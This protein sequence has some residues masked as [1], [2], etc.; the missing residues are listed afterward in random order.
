MYFQYS[1]KINRKREGNILIIAFFKFFLL[2]FSFLFSFPFLSACQGKYLA[3]PAKIL[4]Y[5]K[6]FSKTLLLNPILTNFVGWQWYFFGIMASFF[7]TCYKSFKKIEK[8]NSFTLCLHIIFFLISVCVSQS[9]IASVCWYRKWKFVFSLKNLLKW[10][11]LKRG[12]RWC[13]NKM[14]KYWTLIIR[15]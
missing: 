11:S 7:F 12:S 13:I 3:S 6:L 10:M 5:L 4:K 1:N 2:F 8:T 15:L 14:R 9:V